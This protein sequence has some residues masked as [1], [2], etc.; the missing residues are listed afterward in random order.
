VGP[1]TPDV[2]VPQLRKGLRS[3][4]RT[5]IFSAN[6]RSMS[7]EATEGFVRVVARKDNHQILGLQAVG[8]GVSEL[9]DAFCYAIDGRLGYWQEGGQE[10]DFVLPQPRGPMAIE[11]KS[12]RRRDNTSGL[13]A[14]QLAFPAARPLVVGTGGIPLDLWFAAANVSV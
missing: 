12:G 4:M 1:W 5:R 11:V 9:S 10:V 6:G 13:G 7:V 2:P 8:H 3:M 14:F